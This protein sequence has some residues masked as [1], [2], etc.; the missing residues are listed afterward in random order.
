MKITFSI[1]V[2]FFA[3]T[4]SWS[5]NSSVNL[6]IK[7]EIERSLDVGLKWLYQEQNSTSGNWGLEEYP[8]LTGLAVR[9][10]LGHPVTG[11]PQKI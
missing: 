7:Q 11:N 4:F 1:F 5:E 8:A 9:S 3:V 10:F 6:S 2:F